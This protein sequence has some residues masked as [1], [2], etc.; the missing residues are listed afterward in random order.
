MDITPVLIDGIN[1]PFSQTHDR[2]AVHGGRIFI[3]AVDHDSGHASPTQKCQIYSSAD[4]GATWTHEDAANEPGSI[5]GLFNSVVD[6][7][8]LI[9]A[10]GIVP[11]NEVVLYRFDMA[12]GVRAWTS[13][14]TGGPTWSS[15]DFN[16]DI[17]E[18]GQ[19]I[20][21]YYNT[22]TF[23]YAIWDGAT[24]SVTDQQIPASNAVFTLNT[25]CRVLVESSLYHFWYSRSSGFFNDVILYHRAYDSINTVWGAEQTVWNDLLT[26]QPLMGLP[27]VWD[28]GAQIALPHRHHKTALSA[29]SVRAGVAIAASGQTEPTWS[30][31]FIDDANSRPQTNGCPVA[32]FTVDDPAVLYLAWTVRVA[33]DPVNNL[34]DIHYRRRTAGVWDTS[35]QVFY[36]LSAAPPLPAPVSENNPFGLVVYPSPG[37][38][39]HGFVAL[40]SMTVLGVEG[41]PGYE[42]T[43][44]F[45]GA[46]AAAA[47]N[48]SHLGGFYT[49]KAG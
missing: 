37:A 23:L 42:S 35:N 41:D 3:T 2:I 17:L 9:V 10:A 12:A 45:L 27:V 30:E 43:A 49:R 31:E 19:Y 33:A 25:G 16:I 6:G 14:I 48:F 29:N 11:S 40:A 5:G 34:G 24:W 44:F 22:P 20:V 18:A 47:R 13:A 7:S 1:F 39:D 21:T 46:L 26:N 32:A 38:N 8:L 4:G 15:S 36:D 28:S